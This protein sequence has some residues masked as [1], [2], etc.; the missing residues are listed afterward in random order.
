MSSSK[1]DISGVFQPAAAAGNQ[2]SL[3]LPASSVRVRKNGIEF[4]SAR[5][6]PLWTE[7]SVELHSPGN[8]AKLNASGIVVACAGTRHTGYLVTMLFL[9]LSPRSQKQLSAMSASQLS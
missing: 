4:Q 8:V 9:S 3:R 1:L 5:A 6:I 2:T 7:M